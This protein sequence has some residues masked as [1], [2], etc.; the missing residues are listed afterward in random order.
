MSSQPNTIDYIEF[1]AN[2]FEATKHF[3]SSV[4]GWTFEDYGEEYT[5]FSHS[6]VCGGFYKSD[7]T[8]STQNGG[9]L[10]VLYSPNL[11]DT[12]AKIEQAGG[13]IQ[14]P[15]FLFPGGRRFHFEEPSGNELAV[16]S[17][18]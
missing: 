2:D 9:A 6:G 14:V 1:P 3:F 17:D 11:E 18:K 15:I 12:Q 16:W 4:F 5:A 8:S 13:K 7:L 10:V